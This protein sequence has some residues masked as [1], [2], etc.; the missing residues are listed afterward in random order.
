MTKRRRKQ[1]AALLV[2]LMVLLLLGVGIG[3][4]RYHVLSA[5][6]PVSFKTEVSPATRA[7]VL[8]QPPLAR[9]FLYGYFAK[10]DMSFWVFDRVIPYEV[11][12]L[13]APNPGTKQLDSTL[14]ISSQRLGPYLIDQSRD[15]HLQE[16]LPAVTWKTAALEQEQSGGLVLRGSTPIAPEALNVVDKHWT[17]PT[18]QEEAFDIGSEQLEI[19]IDNRDGGGYTIARVL[20]DEGLVKFPGTA[21]DLVQALIPITF[22]RCGATYRDHKFVEVLFKV[23]CKTGTSEDTMTAVQAYVDKCVEAGGTWLKSMYGVAFQSKSSI[24][25]TSVNGSLKFSNFDTMI[26]MLA[27]SD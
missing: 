20:S 7:V 1:L 23:E 2:G 25:G 9:G 22:I 19:L 8:L 27:Y 3:D 12:L 18:K 21:Q 14:F 13:L 16:T 6:A 24:G 4:R 5:A 15:L 10:A 17:D 26:W 11:A